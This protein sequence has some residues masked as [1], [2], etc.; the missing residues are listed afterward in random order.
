MLLGACLGGNG[1]N[2]INSLPRQIANYLLNLP[3][4]TW[5]ILGFLITL[6]LF[7]PRLVFL[8]PSMIMQF[9]RDVPVAIMSTNTDFL[10]ITAFSYAWLHTGLVPTIIYPPFTLVFFA[11]FT[12]V[13]YET[14]YRILVGI[15][16]ICYLLTTLIFP[17][18]I[19]QNKGTSAFEILILVT[20]LFSY[21]LQF[22]LEQGQW[23]LI[24]FSCSVA[25]IYIFHRQPKYRWLAYL[26]FSISVQLKLFP[27]I[28]VFT[29]IEDFSDWK[30]NI[31]RIIGLGVFNIL[32]LF[33]LGLDP[34][35]NTMEALNILS[36]K[37][38]QIYT[39]RFNLSIPSFTSFFLSKNI[40]PRKHVILWLIANSWLL[41]L[42]FLALFGFCFLTIIFQAYKKNVTG[43][44]PYVFLACFIGAC[45]I[46]SIS[47]DY[48]LSMLPGC[49]AISIPEILL[50]KEDKNQ[51]LDILLAFIFSLAY[52]S[53]LYLYTYK[54][55]IVGNNFPALMLILIICAIL[56]C[57]KSNKRTN[58]PTVDS[59]I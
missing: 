18:W 21:G 47:L 16:L 45:I 49:I 2:V 37:T 48:K 51:P 4:L 14:G 40:L 32:A 29:L 34:V 57:I 41:Q 5:I 59:K 23:N 22:E 31:K 46:P 11:P 13:S 7:F 55:K 15:I 56:S 24:A 39:S 6:I 28:F 10:G 12:L 1:Y 19:N 38:S 3:L 26:L 50:S 33:I 25:A 36:Q 53:M 52:S 35:L 20:G 17:Q 43:F 58:D 27:A 30:K 8:H 9:N 54:P 42:L 44:N